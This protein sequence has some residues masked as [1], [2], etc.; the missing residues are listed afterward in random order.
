MSA[1]THSRL[2]IGGGLVAA[3]AV[4][5]ATAF[6]VR[7]YRCWRPWCL[8]WGATKSEAAYGMPGDDL[9]ADAGSVSTRAVQVDAPPSAIWPWLVQMGPGRGGAYTYDWIE[10]L[11]GLH[12]HSADRILP[13]YQ[14]LKVGDKQQ[15]GK[16]GP[17]MR[18]TELEPKRS[19]VFRSDDGNWVWAFALVPD[20]VGTRLISRNR[21][22]TRDASSLAKVLNTYAMEPGSLIM[23]RKMLL[24]IKDRA[25]RLARAEAGSRPTAGCVGRP[26]ASAA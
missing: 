9:L 4:A 26:H 10:N 15:L 5:V 11:M 13:E 2:V 14:S 6:E 8:S 3:G 22:A 24:G 25:E 1:A 19:L 20:S 17:V 18:V 23:E 12:M 16:R 21:I 7:T